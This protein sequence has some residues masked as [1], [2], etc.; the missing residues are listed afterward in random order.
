MYIIICVYC[1]KE[2]PNGEWCTCEHCGHCPK[3]GRL[4]SHPVHF[5]EVVK[6]DSPPLGYNANVVKNK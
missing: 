1:R 5:C 2:T 3:C 6:S 4:T